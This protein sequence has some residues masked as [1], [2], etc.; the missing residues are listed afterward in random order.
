MATDP[1]PSCCTDTGG[2]ARMVCAEFRTELAPADAGTEGDAVVQLL[3]DRRQD[4]AFGL[5]ITGRRHHNVQDNPPGAL[6]SPPALNR[7]R[8][9]PCFFAFWRISSLDSRVSLQRR[10][11]LSQRHY[12]PRFFHVQVFDQVTVDYDHAFALGSGLRVGDDDLAG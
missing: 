4:V 8:G 10:N 1:L 7:D 6:I 11:G 9:F 3:N 12:T 5:H 2:L